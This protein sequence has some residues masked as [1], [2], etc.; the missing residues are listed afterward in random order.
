LGRWAARLAGV[1]VL[2]HTIHNPPFRA[3]RYRGVNKLYETLERLTASITTAFLG[4]SQENIRDFLSRGIGHQDQYRVVY[5]GLEFAKYRVN[6]TKGE[7][8]RRLGFSE[9]SALVGWFGRLNHQKDPLTF[10]RAA[11][12]IADR[13]PNVRFVV[14]GNDLLGDNLGTRVSQLIDHFNLTNRITF[15][16]FR[17]DLPL[18]LRAVDCV[19]H[20]SRYEGMGRIVCESLLCERAVA[21]TNVDGVRE[22]IHSGKR[23]GFLVPPENPSALAEATLR[24]LDDPERASALAAVGRA[25]VEENLSATRMVDDIAKTYDELLAKS[26]IRQLLPRQSR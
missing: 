12:L 1:P 8:R 10:V 17:S 7:A 21:G 3:S 24:L 6:L 25:W 26:A 2:L 13:R 5:S 9:D 14:C 18:I 22:V 20:S 16:G 19:M 4:V 15:L 11:Y 23:G